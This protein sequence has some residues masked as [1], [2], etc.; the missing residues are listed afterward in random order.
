MLAATSLSVRRGRADV[1]TDLTLRLDEGRITALLGPNGSGKTS[2]MLAFLGLL[3]SRG[4]LERFG[5]QHHPDARARGA[6]GFVPQEGGIPTGATALEWVSL[7]AELR[8]ASAA[9]TAR[10]LD[11]LQVPTHRRL[12]RRLSG[13]ERRD[14]CT[15][16]HRLPSQSDDLLQHLL[17]ALH[18]VLHR[19]T[20]IRLLRET[21]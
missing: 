2:S 3:P 14:P 11:A 9:T 20:R 5:S 4:S 8:G 6:I 1:V 15:A 19:S 16:V 12:A 7:Q 21:T 10:I 17:Q 13:G 18:R